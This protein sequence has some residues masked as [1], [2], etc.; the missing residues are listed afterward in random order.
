MVGYTGALASAVWLG[1]TDGTALVTREGEDVF[2]STHAAA[3]WRQFMTQALAALGLDPG[4]YRFRPPDV[5]PA[6]AVALQ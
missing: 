3:I 1:T 2:G 4:E 6:A 5:I